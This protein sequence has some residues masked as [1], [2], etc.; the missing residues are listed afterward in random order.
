M[1]SDKE[2]IG[3]NFRRNNKLGVL[4][5]KVGTS[6]GAFSVVQ[7]GRNMNNQLVN[8]SSALGKNNNYG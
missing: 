8:T 5:N 1:H 2:F 4:S 7:A 3:S 6:D